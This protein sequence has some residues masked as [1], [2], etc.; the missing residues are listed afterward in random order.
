MRHLSPERSRHNPCA[1][2][3][4]SQPREQPI[5]SEGRQALRYDSRHDHCRTLQTL[6]LP[7]QGVLGG[8]EFGDRGH[9]WPP[10]LLGPASSLTFSHFISIPVIAGGVVGGP[11]FWN[12]RF[13]IVRG[14]FD[15]G[16]RDRRSALFQFA[17]PCLEHSDFI[18]VFP[19]GR[20]DSEQ[21]A[22]VA[23]R[24]GGARAPA[25]RGAQQ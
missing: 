17:C 5:M 1:A 18:N 11:G 14:G 19:G 20:V 9:R 24:T 6:W 15:R 7:F 25:N 13:R 12:L 4:L 3:V 10:G 16:R 22:F 2:N 8:F 21:F 23:Q